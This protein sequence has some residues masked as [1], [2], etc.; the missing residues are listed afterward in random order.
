MKIFILLSLLILISFNS[1]SQELKEA[2]F[3]RTKS[4]AVYVEL[5]GNGLGYSFNYDQRFKNRL[6]G[7]GFKAGASYFAL[8]GASAATFPV[9]V[10]YLLGKRG[11]YFELGLGATYLFAADRS[12]N[13]SPVNNQAFADGITGNMILGY[14]SEPEDG[15]FLF[16]ASITPFFGNGIFWPL[17]AG[18][19]FGYAF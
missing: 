2:D 4:R 13:F 11:K 19:S 5:L 1:F 16:R 9:G 18:V 7:L 3:A 10:N 17:F 15:G 6:D 14:R 8:A 12:N